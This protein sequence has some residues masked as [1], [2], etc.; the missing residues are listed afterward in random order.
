MHINRYNNILSY[1]C[2]KVKNLNETIINFLLIINKTTDFS[3]SFVYTIQL[4]ILTPTNLCSSDRPHSRCQHIHCRYSPDRRRYHIPSRCFRSRL[5]TDLCLHC[6]HHHCRPMRWYR[7]C[8]L[9]YRPLT[10]SYHC[11]MCC[12]HQY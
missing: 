6:Q 9:G 8:S 4:V 3:V 2:Q 1:F 5:S 12:R 7:R 11:P 10:M